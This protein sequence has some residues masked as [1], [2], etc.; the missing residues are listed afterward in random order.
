MSLAVIGKHKITVDTTTIANG[1]SLAAYL[2]DA[3]GNF[4]TSQTIQSIRR[5]DVNTAGERAE[6]SAHTSGDYGSFSLAVRRDSRTSGTSAD[7]DYASFN[8]NSSGDLYTHDFAANAL[9]T[10]IDADTSSIATDA[11]TI[12]GDTTS[13]DATLTALSKAEDSAHVSGDQGVMALVVRNDAGGSLTSANGDYS[14]LQVDATGNLR[15]AGTFSVD[16]S[17]D[18]AEDSAHSSGDI[19]AFVLGV[20][21][22]TLTSSTSADGDYAAFKVNSVGSLYTHDTSANSSL[23]SILSELQAI[24]FAEDSAHSSGDMGVMSLA[25]RNDSDSALAGT[26]GD[27]APTQV[28]ALG[29][30]KVISRANVSNLQQQV[31]LSTSATALPASA[32]ANRQNILIQNTSNQSMWIGSATV[33]SSG[34]TVG[35][36]IPKGGS[37]MIDAGPTNVIY[38]I[39]ASGTPNCTVW[40]LS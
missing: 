39:V 23:S 15:V 25:V 12:A 9:L 21:Q 13:I 11:S 16:F 33:T 29:R 38:G 34:A 10:T 30:V 28:D 35:I 22:D 7:G 20:R 36:E 37:M 24:T 6:D 26:S 18:Y 2:A 32:L 40:E 5:L 31:G 19:G 1:D 4:L 27:Y 14:P 8:V 17:Y 3:A